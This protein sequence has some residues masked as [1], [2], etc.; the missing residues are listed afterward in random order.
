MP[1]AVPD[2]GNGNGPPP[3]SGRASYRGG[4]REGRP[5]MAGGEGMRAPAEE[6]ASLSLEGEGREGRRRR[7]GEEPVTRP[8]HI[9]DKQGNTFMQACDKICQC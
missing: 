3:A 2:N 4:G 9:T 8:A 6:L 1:Q 7:F 5:G